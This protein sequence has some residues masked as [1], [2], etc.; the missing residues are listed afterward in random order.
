MG[1][2]YERDSRRATNG[3]LIFFSIAKDEAFEEEIRSAFISGLSF[4]AYRFPN[5]SM[6]CYGSSEGYEVG[7]DHPGFVIGRFE[8]GLPI[9][10]IPYNGAK[11]NDTSIESYEMPD[12]S[13][14]YEEYSKE[15]EGIVASLQNHPKSKVVAARVLIKE[16][17]FDIAELFY[18]LCQRFP[19]AFVFCFSTPATGCWIGASPELLLSGRED[20]LQSMALAGTRPLGAIGEWDK[21]NIEEQ[22][23]VTDYIS[24]IFKAQNLFPSIGNPQTLATGKIEHI[25]TGISATRDKD[26]N[27]EKMIRALSPTPALCGEPKD[28]ALKKIHEYEKFDRGCYG[29]FCGPY[30]SISDFSF[31]VVLRC[32]SLTER[33]ICLYAG[34]GITNHSDVESEWKETE[35][36]LSNTFGL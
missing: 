25:C 27:L 1:I 9:I 26:F 33:K 34:G 7:L 6:M 12:T 32:A 15:V 20:N 3:P 8:P 36:K 18:T 23:I 35:M 17:E 22:R 31:N 21:K 19:D 28:F 10:T 24:D 30:H 5:D 16:N 2:R 29:G 14:K 4:Y 13:T 11:S